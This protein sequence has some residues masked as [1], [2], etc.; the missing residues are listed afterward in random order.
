MTA[1][2]PQV[3][4]V[5]AFKD[6]TKPESI[7][8]RHRG[9]HLSRIDKALERWRDGLGTADERIARLFDIVH[10]CRN[11][12]DAKA[13]KNTDTATFRRAG[14]VNLANQAFARLQYEIFERRKATNNYTGSMQPLV[15]G[16]RHERTTYLQSGKQTATSGSTA[17]ALVSFAANLNIDLQGKT[18][19]TLTTAE[20]QHLVQTHAPG[21]LMETEVLFMKK[22]DR[23]GSLVVIEGGLLFD[24]P[25]TKFDT[26]PLDRGGFPYV[27][28]E[29]GNMYSTDHVEMGRN[30]PAHQRF[31][32][33]TF[34]AGKDVICAGIVQAQAGQIW[35]IDNNSGHYKPD[36]I[37]LM[38]ALMMLRECGV[39]LQKMRVGLKEPSNQPG[40]L[41]FKYYNNAANFLANPNMPPHE[42]YLE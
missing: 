15:G 23:I 29:Y 8:K 17:S 12:L 13:E 33:S 35:T 1:V 27:I 36:R 32:H 34:N 2:A 24:G 31:N 21:A 26:G 5:R 4:G 19:G 3:P 10:A 39:D 11:W 18:F 41:A 30:L 22:Q 16:Y 37:Q 14:V 20:F 28:D 38:N 6:S 9:R 7:F 42:S 40:R 25:S